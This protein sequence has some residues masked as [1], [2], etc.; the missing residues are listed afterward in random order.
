MT[1]CCTLGL[2]TSVRA[3]VSPDGTLST[4]VTSPNNLNFT[5]NDGN[6]VG[7][8]LFHS[9][10]EFSVPNNGSAVFQNALDVQNI[11]SRVTGGSLSQINGLIQAQGTA[12]LFL[13]NP[14]GIFFGQNARLNIGGSF[15]ATTADSL[16][17]GDGI[18]FSAT[19][20]QA[21]PLLTVNIPIGLRFRDS[22][23]NITNQSVVQDNTGFGI[24][25]QVNPGNSLALVGGNVSLEQGGRLTAAGGRIELG[26]LAGAGTVG[27]QTTGNTF[28][29]NF[30]ANGLSNVSLL[31]D[32]RVAVR[33]NGGGEIVVN[34]NIFT[35][36]NG[37][38]L[39]GGIEGIAT[40]NG[41]D[42]IVNSN[43]F[44]I[45]GVGQSGIGAGIGQQVVDGASG[46]AGNIIVNT[47]SFNAS[48][49]AQLQNSVLFTGTGNAGDITINAGTISFVNGSSINADT[50][51]NGNAGNVTINASNISFD[52]VSSDGFTSG[53]F[54]NIE[55]NAVGNAGGIDITTGTLSLK[56]GAEIS[57]GTF[58]AGN[59][60]SVKIQASDISFDGVGSNGRSSAIFSAVAEN[61]R[62]NAG[63]I[64]ITTGKLSLRDGAFLTASTFGMGNAGTVKIQ[65]SDISFD[66]VGSNGFSSGAF[67][68]V[69]GDAVG[70][71]GGI[72]ITT[73]TLSITNGGVVNASTFA[74]GDAGTV[75]IQASD[76]IFA[77]GV[78]SNG[79]T[80]SIR[81]NV[82]DNAIGNAGGVDISTKNLFFT[83]GA[84][85]TAGTFGRGNAGSLK[86]QA[87]DIFFD[88]VGSTGFTSGI[89]NNVGSFG[90]GN[91]GD[92][93][94]TTGTLSL[95][96][97]AVLSASTFG[98]GNAGNISLQVG[99]A[100][101]LTDSSQI[102]SFVGSGGEG[103]GGDIDIRGRS[104]TLTN[105]SQIN[106]STSGQG[107]AGNISIQVGDAI[108][109]TDSSQIASFVG[110]G[111]EGIGGDIDIRARSLTLTNGSQIQASLFRRVGDIPGGIGTGGSIKI[112]ASDFV[113]ISGFDPVSLFQ[114]GIFAS[115]ETG[116][117]G[118]GGSIDITTGA[119]RLT[120]LGIVTAGTANGNNG[121]DITINAKTFEVT[122][123]L[124]Q[125]SLSGQSEAG[126]LFSA[127]DIQL[128]V[129]DSVSLKDSSVI[130]SSTSGQG[131][132]GN[133]SLQ[134]GD[135]IALTN[136]SQIN[137]STF[138]IGD[139]GNI[140]L[141]VGD[142][143]AL[144][145]SSL[146][147]SFVGQGGEGIGG[148]IDIRGRS[149]TL[150]EGS[151][152]L[153]ALF[154]EGNGL[155]GGKGRAGNIEI[156]AADFINIL[157]VDTTGF[158]SGLFAS[159]ERGTT[160][161]SPQAAGNINLTTGD[162]RIADGAVVNAL[163]D[164][165]GDAG[166]ITINA[167][168]FTA[169]GGGQLIT[170]TRNSG[171][172]GNINL[173]I[174]DRI[175]I[176]GSDP[177]FNQRFEQAAQSGPFDDIVNNQGPASGIFANT[178]SAST[179]N[180]G[181]ITI[182]PLQ[183]RF[184][185]IAISD[186]AEVT[187]D[188]Q[189]QGQGGEI[190]ITGNTLSLDRGIIS[191]S[192][193][194][195][196]GGDITLNL[197]DFLRLRNESLISAFSRFD[198]NGGNITIDAPFIVAFPRN[199][200]IAA[201]A[202]RGSGGQVL[203]RTRRLFGI[204]PLSLVDLERLRP[205]DLDFRQLPT[206][207][208]VSSSPLGPQVLLTSPD[209]DPSRGLIELP[210]TVTDTT[211]KI[212]QSP[213]RQGFGN[214]FAVTGRGGLP[215]TPNETLSSNNVRVDLLQPVASSGNSPS[216]T[217][218]PATTVT[219]RRVP[220]QGWIFNDKG[221]VV[222]T[223]YDPTNTGSQRPFSTAACP[224][225]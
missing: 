30:P 74:T 157:G 112:N 84:Q 118:S 86:I 83:N 16:L 150:T 27:L 218:K 197:R 213:C 174:R 9:F 134:V 53:I 163:T 50:F 142:A 191:A 215:T 225:R 21:A 131:N 198:G 199:N 10:R 104:L 31:D 99:D 110:S 223:A 123:G 193:Q 61:G 106:S 108:A 187:V 221:Q 37:G 124:V 109:L 2:M 207:D 209:V 44:N 7:G 97:G 24:G 114:S 51:G 194:S 94:I 200:D 81:S 71:A 68:A 154:R 4:T 147:T 120:N 29:L 203:I 149:F 128:N 169:S 127:G 12:N 46:N 59:A 121:G 36:T 143:I 73:G 47:K 182:K 190:S 103:I 60:G 122:N 173:N 151:Q 162:F 26:G 13:L 92:I 153:T 224:A 85:I 91:G 185:T 58:G 15:F 156:N 20:P 79:V 183:N 133:V 25:L 57:T 166:N 78:G 195:A 82:E 87:S 67:S 76:T 18:E 141:Q 77:S 145:D 90:I 216:A 188:S 95:T 186:G 102:A 23:G 42:I 201:N 56:N 178:A 72:D 80:S 148:D 196:D 105:G 32:A 144:T 171:N 39:V 14:A 117:T 98:R 69:Q 28:T 160:A 222:L 65:A 139:A 172:A 119:F 55:E 111:G 63:G 132:A 211:Q 40:R 33:S 34:A 22:P 217:I 89:F 204:T 164:N 35:A 170:T 96:N 48:S 52:G 206:S 176:S 11:I 6:R 107:N 179:G 45:S 113:N 167:N 165:S 135:A 130:N 64:D 181:S 159:A 205:N 62:G 219:A 152:I 100:I 49:G 1:T 19:N 93:D 66:G 136:N 161:I 184:P 180:G 88:G 75:K 177:N 70:N 146:I 220:A 214:E 138:G 116:S 212:A 125:T 43:E 155:S 17:F 54:S 115:A 202:G 101:A 208:I 5:I 126:R 192:T 41:G 175:T 8:N 140:S 168:T 3:Q 137:S 158:S 210:E 129:T 38:R 189:G